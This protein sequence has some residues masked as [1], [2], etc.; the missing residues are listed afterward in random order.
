MCCH[1]Q[2]ESATWILLILQN[3]QL[4][5]NSFCIIYFYSLHVS[6]NLVLI[7]RRVNCINTSVICHCVGD[8]SGMQVGSYP[9]CIPDGHLHRVT[10]TRCC[11]DTIDSPNDEHKVAWNM[12]RIEINVYKRNFASSWLFCRIIPRCRVTRI[13]KKKSAPWS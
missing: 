7:I 12:S 3:N 11:I 6:S 9:T 1:L 13:F 2:K 4:D 5:A 8:P 10:Y